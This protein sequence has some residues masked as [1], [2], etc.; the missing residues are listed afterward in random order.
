MGAPAQPAVPADRCAREIG[1]FLKA[2]CGALA[3]AER[4]PVG[5]QPAR[6][7]RNAQVLFCS[8]QSVN[9]YLHTL[10]PYARYILL[11]ILGCN[12]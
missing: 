12:G 1:G 10:H 5:P 7:T 3:A 9:Q 2:R 6:C 11:I 8:W 4:Q